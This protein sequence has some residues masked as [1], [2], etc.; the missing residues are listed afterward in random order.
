[1]KLKINK[2]CDLSSISVLPPH[3]RRGNT[4]TSRADGSGL[5]RSQASQLRSMSQQSFSQG[6]SLS[7]LSQNSI[8][9]NLTNEPRLGSQERDNSMKR[10]SSL[11]PSI[12]MREDSQV[13]VS[14]SCNSVTRRWSSAPLPEYK[15]QVTE[16]LDRRIGLVE[17]SVSRLAMIL[18]SIQSDVM[19]VN[20]SVKE[21]LLGTEGLRQK[22]VLQEN[23]LQLITKGEEDIRFSLEKSLESILDQLRM[24]SDHNKMKEI[25]STLSALPQQ[26]RAHLLRLQ[27][28]LSQNLTKEIEKMNSPNRQSQYQQLPVTQPPKR[29]TRT[30]TWS[31]KKKPVTVEIP[32]APPNGQTKVRKR[33]TGKTKSRNQTTATSASKMLSKHTKRVTP[34][35][36]QER[37]WRIII[38]SDEESEGV[39]SFL[40]EEKEMGTQKRLIEEVKVE[41]ERILRQARRNKRKCSSSIILLSE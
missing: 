28:E 1:M 35:K 10:F 33:S 15:C 27:S 13:P 20:K 7:Q 40:L 9:E 34:V 36:K 37:D 29:T 31:E 17:T 24:E 2:A 22:M 6:V 4:N 12:Y 18:D 30:A 16:E 14:K 19:Q 5:G 8:E 39:F 23:T 38:D 41:T 26:I 32:D 3:S 21:V 11:V 25:E